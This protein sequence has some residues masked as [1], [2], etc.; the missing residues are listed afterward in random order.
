M[1]HRERSL[2]RILGYRSP[3]GVVK[4]KRLHKTHKNLFAEVGEEDLELVGGRCVSRRGTSLWASGVRYG[5]ARGGI[6]AILKVE[7]ECKKEFRRYKKEKNGRVKTK[8]E[9]NFLK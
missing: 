3:L 8:R 7:K 2:R 5:C 6:A 4:C 1:A 9:N